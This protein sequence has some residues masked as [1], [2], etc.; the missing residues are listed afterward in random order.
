MAGKKVKVPLPEIPWSENSHARVWN[1]IAEISKPV[2]YKVLYGKKDKNEVC[3][4]LY[5]AF[6]AF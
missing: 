2:N 3:I 1:L 4:T 5:F 6:F